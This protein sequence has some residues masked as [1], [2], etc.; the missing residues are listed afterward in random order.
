M[1][2]TY[3]RLHEDLPAECNCLVNGRKSESQLYIRHSE[4]GDRTH[5]REWRT[6]YDRNLKQ[7][8][9][10]FKESSDYCIRACEAKACS[11]NKYSDSLRDSILRKYRDIFK[12]SPGSSQSKKQYYIFRLGTSKCI[13]ANTPTQSNPTHCSLFKSDQFNPNDIEEIERGKLFE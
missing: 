3:D 7:W 1:S 8:R 13:V 12:T 2:V 10:N 5:D 4:Y 9:D 11:I 6:H